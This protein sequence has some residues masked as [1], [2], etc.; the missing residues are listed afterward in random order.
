MTTPR[1]S[2]RTIPHAAEGV[3]V[4]LS[5]L[6][7]IRQLIWQVA[8]GDRRPEQAILLI[9]TLTAGGISSLESIEGIEKLPD[10]DLLREIGDL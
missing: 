6:R 7:E 8:R 1:K 4:T 10:R 9:G 3:D 2:I 5:A